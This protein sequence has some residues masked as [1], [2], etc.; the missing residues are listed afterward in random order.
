MLMTPE[1]GHERTG[2]RAEKPQS[3]QQ[4]GKGSQDEARTPADKR[5]VTAGAAVKQSTRSGKDRKQTDSSKPNNIR[6]QIQFQEVSNMKT[7]TFAGNLEFSLW[8]KKEP[9]DQ[10]HRIDEV[11]PHTSH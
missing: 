3:S 2:A 4:M 7:Q 11:E 9:P 5:E 6:A 8:S 1:Q 10:Q